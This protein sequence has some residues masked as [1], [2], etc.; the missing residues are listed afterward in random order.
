MKLRL[1]VCL[2]TLGVAPG[3]AVRTWHTDSRPIPRAVAEAS[4]QKL[5]LTL[6]DGS[7]LT[8]IWPYLDRDS[9]RGF[10]SW[11]EPAVV[12]VPLAD[13]QT[14]ARLRTNWP[15]SIVAT[16]AATAGIAVGVAFVVCATSGCLDF[17]LALGG[18]VSRTSSP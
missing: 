4:H 12:P 1:T 18:L 9:V 11:S 3:C 10:R 17:H 13:V 8:L 16:T 14:V 7:R 5:R 6:R 15:L 2:L